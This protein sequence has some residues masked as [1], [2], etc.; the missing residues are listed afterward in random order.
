M[1]KSK[2]FPS[3]IW[4]SYQY[5]NTASKSNIY[6]A[7]ETLCY[8][9]YS[10]IWKSLKLVIQLFHPVIP[11]LGRGRGTRHMLTFSLANAMWHETRP[12]FSSLCRPAFRAEYSCPRCSYPALLSDGGHPT[13]LPN[14][15]AQSNVYTDLAGCYKDYQLLNPLLSTS[16]GPFF[17]L[18]ELQ[19]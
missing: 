18:N 15:P 10:S 5:K 7:T 16:S 3:C 17:F 6:K 11:F 9:W 4:I 8:H 13:C 12:I 2:N 19:K 14:R 1:A